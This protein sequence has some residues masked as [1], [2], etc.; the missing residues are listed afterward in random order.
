MGNETEG[1]GH[2]FH[3]ARRVEY[4]LR[5]IA[6]KRCEL[7][8]RLIQG[9]NGMLYTAQERLNTNRSSLMSIIITF[10]PAYLVNVVTPRTNRPASDYVRVTGTQAG[11]PHLPREL[12]WQAA[13]TAV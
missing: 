11:A 5:I 8:Q 3:V 9:V 10:A 7:F 1:I 4:D 6:S 2:G 13:S 12:R